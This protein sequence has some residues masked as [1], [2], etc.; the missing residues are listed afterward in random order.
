MAL[1]IPQILC[2]F[3]A[4]V[5][6]AGSAESIGR[7]CGRLVT[8]TR[9]QAGWGRKHSRGSFAGYEPSLHPGKRVGGAD[10]AQ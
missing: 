10:L 9:R 5:A 3:K 1:S 7:I 6:K 8:S 4:D 2:E